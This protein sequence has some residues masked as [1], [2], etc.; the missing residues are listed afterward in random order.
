MPRTYDN[1]RRA[2]SAEKTADRIVETTET[3]LAGGPVAGVT[4][5]AIAEGAG[6]SMQ[7]VLRHHG[8]RDGCIEAVERRVLARIAAQRGHVPGGD[9]EAGLTALL[10]HYEA[11]GRLVLNL[12]SQET[13]DP[14]ARGAV[15]TGRSYHR[16]WVE[17]VFGSH[18][19]PGDREAVDALVAA[20][21]LYLWKLL[22]I[23]LGRSREEVFAVI[24]RLVLSILEGS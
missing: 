9:V 11:E 21:D 18:L 6:V 2:R 13:T 12:L 14:F 5:Q 8:S 15:Q 1:T 4:L 24:R 10:D 20:T 17:R 22:R 3:L 7:T 23:D 16:T 19:R